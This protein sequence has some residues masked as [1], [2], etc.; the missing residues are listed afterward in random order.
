M[1]Q[2]SVLCMSDVCLLCCLQP[3][4]PAQPIYVYE[5]R[6]LENDRCYI[7][8]SMDVKRRL[9]AH[10]RNPPARMRRDAA[11]CVPFEDHF[12]LT[13]LTVVHSKP[14]ADHLESQFL[15]DYNACSPDGYNRLKGAPG[16]SKK[17]WFLHGKG[18][19]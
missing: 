19:I 18:V 10:R 8:Q 1:I 17:F 3:P 7:G 15:A 11:K 12:K 9:A 6:C 4:P 13:V 14:A 16:K 2:L 5:L